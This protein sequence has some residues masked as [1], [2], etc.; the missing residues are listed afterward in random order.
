[1]NQTNSSIIIAGASG[2]V[3]I[4]TTLALLKKGMNVILVTSSSENISR[5]NDEVSEYRSQVRLILEDVSDYEAM[6]SMQE[7][8]DAEGVNVVGFVN[9][10]GGWLSTPIGDIDSTDV[11]WLNQRLVGTVASSINAFASELRSKSGIYVLVSSPAAVVPMKGSAAYSASKAAAESWV[12]SLASYFEGTEARTNIL[13]VHS[14]VSDKERSKYPERKFTHA[15]DIKF[16]ADQISG[17]WDQPL[18]NGS[19]TCL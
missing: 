12:N 14:L 2:S 17:L 1:M 7:T 10:I 6:K 5:L 4:A 15:T 16:L 9:L 11:D 19:R 8:L 13:V 18:K 3:G